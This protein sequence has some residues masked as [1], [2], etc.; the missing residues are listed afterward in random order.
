[1]EHFELCIV[2]AGVVGLALA[3]RFARTRPRSFSILLLDKNASFGQE[4]SSRNSEVIHAG[5]YYTPGSLK[6][7]LCVEGRNL[8]YQYCREHDI[9]QRRTGKFIVAQD[10]ELESLERVSRTAIQNGVE[11]LQWVSRQALQE[12]EPLVQAAHALYSPS[13]GIIDSHAFMNS[14]LREAEL[15]GVQYVPLTK[16]VAVQAQ[17]GHF[18]VQTECG[19]AGHLEP[20]TFRC[21]YFINAAGLHTQ[22][23]AKCIMGLD[24]SCVPPLFLSRGCYFSLAGKAP[25]KHLI[26]PVP[27]QHQR[28]LG[29]HATLDLSGQVRFGPDVE[30]VETIDY[31]VSEERR[32]VFV[33]AI[34]RYFPSLRA[35]QLQ[36]DYAGIRPKLRGPDGGVADFLIQDETTHGLP[37]LVQLFGIESPGLTAS[38]AIARLVADEGP[39]RA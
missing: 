1:M 30:Y 35:D 27:E 9:P 14:L 20:F 6:A 36:A 33:E 3:Q 39:L 34:R 23:L 11:D 19:T 22:A 2:G 28:G 26:Y 4:T 24:Q 12:Q 18:T 17:S 10:D 31:H 5:L 7:K 37:G 38:L 21:Q 13:T 29:I 25:F 15:A 8:L 32:A 16:V